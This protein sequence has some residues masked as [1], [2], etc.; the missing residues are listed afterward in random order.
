M[1]KSSKIIYWIATSL[2]AIGMLQS[3]IFA[4]IKSKEWIKLITDLGYPEYL[5]I[6]C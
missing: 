2:L 1:K 3:G 4:I 5:L 6:L